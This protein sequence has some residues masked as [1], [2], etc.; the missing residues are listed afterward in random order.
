MLN[1]GSDEPATDD[2]AQNAQEHAVRMVRARAAAKAGGPLS[3]G[4]RTILDGKRKRSDGG[5]SEP[6]QPKAK[7]G[8]AKRSHGKR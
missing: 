3:A 6:L 8:R 4:T 1:L 5:E 2:T 7:S